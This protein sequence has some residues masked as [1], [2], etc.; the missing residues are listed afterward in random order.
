MIERPAIDHDKL[1]E[2][3]ARYGIASLE[4]FGSVARE[5]ETSTSDL[6][7]L[8]ELKPGVQLGW[9]IEDLNQ[10]LTELFGREVELVAKRA[11]HPLLR[12]TV[13]GES[14]LLYAA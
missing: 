2:I 3:C 1:Q 9:E 12:D 10:E 14:R 6:D 7:V 4:V 11:L 13:L 5:Q 8:Y